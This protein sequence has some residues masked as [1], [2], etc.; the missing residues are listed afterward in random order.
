MS[1]TEF[2][3]PLNHH[4]N[5]R[6]KPHLIILGTLLIFLGNMLACLCLSVCWTGGRLSGSDGEG[7][8]SVDLPSQPPLAVEET[9]PAQAETS[10]LVSV[11]LCLWVRLWY[12]MC[13]CC[14]QRLSVSPMCHHLLPVWMPWKH[15]FSSLPSHVDFT[16]TLCSL[17]STIQFYIDH[18]SFI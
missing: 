5:K 14:C 8:S 15:I 11:S 2:V 18:R 4:H 6:F 9:G 16:I 10:G 13:L 7:L 3:G 1:F 17:P 12:S